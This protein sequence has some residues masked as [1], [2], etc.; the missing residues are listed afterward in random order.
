MFGRTTPYVSRLT[1]VS[2]SHINLPA[3]GQQ[4][5]KRVKRQ[6]RDKYKKRKK[7]E[8]RARI[9]GKKA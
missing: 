4:L 2:L 6:R 7:A 9:S 3:M 8:V 1:G 5:K